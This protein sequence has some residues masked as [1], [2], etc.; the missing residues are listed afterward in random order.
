MASDSSKFSLPNFFILMFPIRNLQ[1]IHQNFTLQSINSMR[2]I[3]KSFTLLNFCVIR[4][5][6]FVVLKQGTVLLLEFQCNEVWY[7]LKSI[8]LLNSPVILSGNSF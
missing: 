1:S 4:Y 7:R 8:M 6:S 3:P 5:L 2:L